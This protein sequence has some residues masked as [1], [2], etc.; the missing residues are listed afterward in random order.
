LQQFATAPRGEK[1]IFCFF[2]SGNPNHFF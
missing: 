1:E 2:G